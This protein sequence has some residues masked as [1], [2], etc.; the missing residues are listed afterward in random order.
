MIDGSE[1]RNRR[2]AL[3]MSLRELS[4]M[5]E[6]SESYL[7]KIEN[8]SDIK[9]KTYILEK[10]EDELQLAERIN[11][12]SYAEGDYIPGVHCPNLDTLLDDLTK[13]LR[14]YNRKGEITLNETI[15]ILKRIE[16]IVK[17]KF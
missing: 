1:I 9:T 7:S 17:I 12:H 13:L 5:V 11:S 3:K 10:I 8:N 4:S 14:A 15:D 6:I 2:K 16:T